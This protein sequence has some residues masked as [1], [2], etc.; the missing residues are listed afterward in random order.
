M[1]KENTLWTII[2]VLGL[3][4]KNIAVLPVTYALRT[5]W[6]DIMH[7]LKPFGPRVL[8]AC[9]FEVVKI[10]LESTRKKF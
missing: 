9:A 5:S 4:L 2:M 7:F 6:V 10:S 1:G 3:T 8:A